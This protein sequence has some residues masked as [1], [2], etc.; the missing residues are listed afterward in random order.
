MAII[1]F[2]KSAAAFVIV[3]VFGHPKGT[4]LIISASLA[5][6][7]EFS[8]ILAGLGLTLGI[9]PQQA[10]NLVLAGAIISIL[11]N[12][13]FFVLLDRFAPKKDPTEQEAASDGAT[14]AR[15]ELTPTALND[16]YI[17]IGY[18]RVGG[19]IGEVLRAAAAPMVVI[20][21]RTA[22]DGG[23][24]A[25]EAIRGNAADPKVLAAANPAGARCMFIAVPNAFEAGTIVEQA[26]AANPSLPIIARA[27]SEAEQE[28]LTRLGATHTI[29]GERELALEMLRRAGISI[30]RPDG[31]AIAP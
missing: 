14:A 12:P 8:F 9:L 10:Q 5:Q 13:T 23:A 4:A 28:H 15:R 21:D 24:T 11:V 29:V 18:G 19:V 25:V 20:E 30:E 22:P 2:G 17:V 3:R 1:L 31:A 27:H 16:H 6:I 7:G 26:R